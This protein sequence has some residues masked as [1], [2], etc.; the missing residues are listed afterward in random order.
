MHVYTDGAASGKKGIWRAGCGVWFAEGSR[1]NISTRPRGKQTVNRAELTAIIL[2]IRKALRWPTEFNRLIVF[3]DS[4]LCVDG[5]NLWMNT[6]KMDG[7]TRGGKKLKNVDLWKLMSRVV[8]TTSQTDFELE[9]RHV[10]AHADIVGNERA[11][12]LAGAAVKKAL[13]ASARTAEE[14]AEGQLNAMADALVAAITTDFDTRQSSQL[15]VEPEG[16][17]P[18]AWCWVPYHLRK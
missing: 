11:D 5:I 15:D 17:D 12:R 7:W 10:P 16:Y 6:W 14:R 4:K 1:F 3:S 13:K 9:V 8:A 18:L 2:A